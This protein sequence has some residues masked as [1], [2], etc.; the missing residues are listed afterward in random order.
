MQQGRN[1]DNNGCVLC[2]L[3]LEE[4]LN[5]TGNPR[6]LVGKTWYRVSPPEG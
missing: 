5:P 1:A 4:E 6:E 2:Q 3:P